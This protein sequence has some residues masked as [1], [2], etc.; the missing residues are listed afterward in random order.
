M[1][2]HALAVRRGSTDCRMNGGKRK[3]L[4]DDARLGKIHCQLVHVGL[5]FLAMGALEIGKL[6]QFQVLRRRAAIGPVGPLL[7]R[8]AGVSE[9]VRAEGDN[10]VAG[11][12]VLAVCHGEELQR[13]RLLLA[14]LVADENDHL[15]DAVDGSLENSL[16]LPDAVFIVSP[17]GLQECVDVS[18]VGDAAVK[19]AGI[20][21]GKYGR[22]G[23]CGRGWRLRGCGRNL[24]L[25]AEACT[26]TRDKAASAI[27]LTKLDGDE[28]SCFSLFHG[29]LPEF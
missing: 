26:R 10:L 7:Q 4:K 3:V 22:G 24:R 6:D 15:A 14:G 16:H 21:L 19:F 25:R 27:A 8:G 1:L 18:L 9:R 28:S 5:R 20:G 13:R 11:D 29:N 17:A 2:G 12:D 23:R